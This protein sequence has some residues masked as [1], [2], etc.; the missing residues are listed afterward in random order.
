MAFWDTKFKQP[1][2]FPALQGLYIGHPEDH[3]LIVIL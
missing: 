1:P 3:L 2:C